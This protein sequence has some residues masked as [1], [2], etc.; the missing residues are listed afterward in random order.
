MQKF[1]FLKGNSTFY[2]SIWEIM[3]LHINAHNLL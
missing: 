1:E 2:G 3:W